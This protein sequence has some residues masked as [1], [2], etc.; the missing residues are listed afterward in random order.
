[1]RPKY[2]RM[3]CKRP[4]LRNL[5]NVRNIPDLSYMYIYIFYF[6]FFFKTHSWFYCL[7]YRILRGTSQVFKNIFEFFSSSIFWREPIHAYRALSNGQRAYLMTDV[8][9][10]HNCKW[11][12][13][14][15]HQP[16]RVL[17]K[18]VLMVVSPGVALY[19]QGRNIQKHLLILSL[20]P[21][22]Y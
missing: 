12:N 7:S 2:R 1:M 22:I 4:G 15:C 6:L 10:N 13:F 14:P 16:F 18:L 3:L 20:A 11:R 17:R 21:S 5:G 8:D 19:S 9:G